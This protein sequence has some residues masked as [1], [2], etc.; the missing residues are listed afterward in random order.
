MIIF[1][2]NEKTFLVKKK[3]KLFFLAYTKWSIKEVKINYKT[4]KINLFQKEK[5]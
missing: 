3:K 1:C 4:E 5:R 2:K